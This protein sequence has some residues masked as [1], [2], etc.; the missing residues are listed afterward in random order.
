[1]NDSVDIAGSYQLDYS[2]IFTSDDPNLTHRMYITVEKHSASGQVTGTQVMQNTGTNL[3][4]RLACD[5]TEK[6]S[7]EDRGS[8]VNQQLGS[9]HYA[10]VEDSYNSW[11]GANTIAGKEKATDFRYYVTGKCDVM[12]SSTVRFTE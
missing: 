10:M 3:L 11:E 7:W 2:R 4:S 6:Q 9:K 1:M 8:Y 5:A 12:P